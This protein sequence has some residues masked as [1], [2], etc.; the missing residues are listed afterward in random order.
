[1]GWWFTANAIVLSIASTK[2]YRNQTYL[3][4]KYTYVSNKYRN[5]SFQK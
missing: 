3:F 2:K 4:Q 1:M 5:S